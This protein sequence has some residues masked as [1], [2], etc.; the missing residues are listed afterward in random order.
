[1]DGVVGLGSFEVAV[2][3]RIVR[4]GVTIDSTDGWDWGG[5]LVTFEGPGQS[6]FDGASNS[7]GRTYK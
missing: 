7:G 5:T 1:M 3:D 6:D 4:V 2:V